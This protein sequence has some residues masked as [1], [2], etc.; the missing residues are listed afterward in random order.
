[1]YLWSWW[2]LWLWRHHDRSRY[3]W[4]VNIRE[5]PLQFIV[6]GCSHER[7]D[8]VSLDS[9]FHLKRTHATDSIA[10]HRVLLIPMNVFMQN[11]WNDSMSFQVQWDSIIII[12]NQ[13]LHPAIKGLQLSFIESKC[14]WSTTSSSGLC[15]GP[16]SSIPYVLQHSSGSSLESTNE[17]L[18]E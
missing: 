2:Y 18:K 15:T 17:L 14:D 1:M 16:S 10:W 6:K 3:A 4:S 12:I 5:D 13:R 11:N 8:M 9:Q 7:S